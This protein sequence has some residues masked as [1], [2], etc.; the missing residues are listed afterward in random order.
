MAV[1]ADDITARFEEA[2]K[3]KRGG[4]YDEAESLLQSVI[5]EQ[6]MN[7]DAYHE[8]GELYSITVDDKTFQFLETAVRIVP[9]SVRYLLTLAKTYAMFGEDDKAK[10]AFQYILRLDPYNDEATK[11]LAYYS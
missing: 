8:L 3:L 2:V 6:P 11:N 4:Q 7:A 10:M 5:A 1:M 9:T